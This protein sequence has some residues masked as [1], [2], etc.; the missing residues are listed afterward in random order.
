[1]FPFTDLSLHGISKETTLRIFSAIRIARSMECILVIFSVSQ[2]SF[3]FDGNIASL[4]CK[5]YWGFQRSPMLWHVSKGKQETDLIL[6][7]LEIK[8]FICIKLRHHLKVS[9]WHEKQKIPHSWNSSKIELKNRRE[10][11][12]INTPNTRTWMLNFLTWHRHLNK[13]VDE[14]N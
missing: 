3:S 2:S 7:R 8:R 9:Q 12:K 5:P 1:M 13:K 4:A 14:L 6:V 10:I 11:G